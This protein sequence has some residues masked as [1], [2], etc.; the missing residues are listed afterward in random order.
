MADLQLTLKVWRQRSSSDKGKFETYDVSGLNSHMSF[1]EM[2]DVLNEKLVRKDKEPIAFD[3][4]CREGICGMCS[5]VINGRAHG[6][7]KG[8]TT[9][10]L[11]MR[12]FKNGDTITIE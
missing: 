6:P 9:C 1:L 3:H 2:M 5:M 10:Q 7:L 12:H 11:H 8:T 4:D